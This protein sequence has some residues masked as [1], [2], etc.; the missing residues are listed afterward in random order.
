[1]THWRRPWWSK[2]LWVD[3]FADGIVEDWGPGELTI[4]SS[5]A[6]LKMTH[7]VHKITPRPEAWWWISTVMWWQNLI[8]PPG[9]GFYTTKAPLWPRPDP[10]HS[11]HKL[12]HNTMTW[13]TMS[14]LGPGPLLCQVLSPCELLLFALNCIAH[15]AVILTKCY[16]NVV[17]MSENLKKWSALCC[18]GLVEHNYVLQNGGWWQSQWCHPWAK[19]GVVEQQE[20][21]R[22][23]SQCAWWRFLW[24]F[25]WRIK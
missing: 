14:V 4:Q 20:K 2:V 13:L 11:G 6:R 12:S 15:V 22:R 3:R 24:Q 23:C 5:Y 7:Y 17:W 19:K 25:W 9:S 16:G 10:Q 1:M 8:L 18:L 21:A